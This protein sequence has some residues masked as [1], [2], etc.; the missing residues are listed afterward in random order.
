MT[1]VLSRVEDR[2]RWCQGSERGGKFTAD[3]QAVRENGAD[4]AGSVE[5][6]MSMC[7]SVL[8]HGGRGVG[9]PGACESMG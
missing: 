7:T 6:V 5:G 9:M 1:Y 2:Q 3:R 4:A 8:G